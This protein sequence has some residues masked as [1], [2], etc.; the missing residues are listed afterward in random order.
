MEQKKSTRKAMSGSTMAIIAL[1]VLLAVS[2]GLGVTLAFFTSNANATGN[3]TLGDPVT[4]GLTQGGASVSTLTFDGNALPGT[5]FDQPIAVTAPANTSDAVIRAKVL[6]TD[7]DATTTDITATT[8]ND[9]TFNATDGY[10]YYNGVIKAN[11]SVEFVSKL[12]VPTSLTNTSANKTL[13][14]TVQVEAIQHANGA[15]ST[16]WTDAPSQ[17]VT[18]YGSGT[19]PV[20]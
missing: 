4:I 1:S 11:N 6:L 15:A 3:V 9:W 16:V 17:W 18:D 2:V 13:T 10:Y 20:T 5:T 8:S 12:T 19:L 14:V 7:N